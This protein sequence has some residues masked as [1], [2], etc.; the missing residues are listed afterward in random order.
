MNLCRNR[1]G[2]VFNFAPAL[3]A[4]ACAPSHFP[5]PPLNER[6]IENWRRYLSC[7][8]T[9]SHLNAYFLQIHPRLHTKSFMHLA[10][11]KRRWEKSFQTDDLINAVQFYQLT[12]FLIYTTASWVRERKELVSPNS[13]LMEKNVNETIMKTSS[14][15]RRERYT[16]IGKIDRVRNS[17]GKEE[18]KIGEIPT[19]I[20]SRPFA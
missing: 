5:P 2:G 13:H 11:V 17:V 8:A 7:Y 1:V 10:V 19:G 14:Y 15:Q 9:H 18:R 20:A 12:S 16:Y 6:W 3:A 4:C